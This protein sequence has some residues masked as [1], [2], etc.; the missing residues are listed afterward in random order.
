MC[1]TLQLRTWTQ[2]TLGLSTAVSMFSSAVPNTARVKGTA[3]LSVV[4]L[5]RVI[6]SLL[7]IFASM[8]ELAGGWRLLLELM[9]LE[10]L[11]LLLRY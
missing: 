9:I 4:I 5:T 6:V 2:V 8:P 11:V 7:G 10:I 1:T 3:A